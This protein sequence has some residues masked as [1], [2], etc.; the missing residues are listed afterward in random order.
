M[1]KN[2]VILFI[3]TCSPISLFAP[4]KKQRNVT[5]TT[6]S[7]ALAEEQQVPQQL[8][9]PAQLAV[10]ADERQDVLMASALT[11]PRVNHQQQALTATAAVTNRRA[12]DDDDDDER[13]LPAAPRSS[14]RDFHQAEEGEDTE[15]FLKKT[16]AELLQG[17]P[18]EDRKKFTEEWDLAT[19]EEASTSQKIPTQAARIQEILVGLWARNVTGTYLKQRASV[20]LGLKTKSQT[21]LE[22]IAQDKLKDFFETTN[23]QKAGDGIRWID[24]ALTEVLE[25]KNEY[26][27]RVILGA[28]KTFTT[29]RSS[30]PPETLL[31]AKQFLI[32]QAK[33]R[34][35]SLRAE[36]EDCIQNVRELSMLAHAADTRHATE[37]G[38]SPILLQEDE[39]AE[40]AKKT[41]EGL[42]AQAS[43]N[44]F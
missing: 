11:L 36:T 35:E 19:G 32:K 26:A 15:A 9:P 23:E 8:V 41:L 39:I 37:R 3:V 43:S 2:I 20:L 33:D 29:P 18:E 17:V 6:T 31:R 16:V 44:K 21:I 14:F 4:P 42:Q 40:M 7:V 13:A 28:L 10:V 38:G 5:S 12:L 30:L 27:T 22:V 1:K 24:E 25:D 34:I